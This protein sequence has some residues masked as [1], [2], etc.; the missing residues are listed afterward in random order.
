MYVYLNVRIV[1]FNSLNA[2]A[3]TK[4]QTNSRVPEQSPSIKCN[5]LAKKK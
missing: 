3:S 1:S 2:H 5:K 4:A